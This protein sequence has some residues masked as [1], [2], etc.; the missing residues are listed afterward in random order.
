MKQVIISTQFQHIYFIYIGKGGRSALTVLGYYIDISPGGRNLCCHLA[1]RLAPQATTRYSTDTKHHLWVPTFANESI[2]VSN[3][4]CTEGQI[5]RTGKEVG[6]LETSASS[7]LAKIEI[8][9]SHVGLFIVYSFSVGCFCLSLNFQFDFWG[10]AYFSLPSLPYWAVVFGFQFFCLF[11][12]L[13]WLPLFL[14]FTCEQLLKSITPIRAPFVRFHFSTYRIFG[15]FSWVILS[16]YRVCS[17][18]LALSIYLADLP[19]LWRTFLLFCFGMGGR[20]CC[21]AQL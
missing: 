2:L 19:L 5:E 6:L 16:L 8:V 17:R 18:L 20:F 21:Y 4:Q 14:S 11:F 3:V 15:C 12:F 9:C 7:R 1:E 13:T 10:Q